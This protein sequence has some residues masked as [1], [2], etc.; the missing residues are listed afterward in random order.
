MFSDFDPSRIVGDQLNGHDRPVKADAFT[1]HDLAAT[2]ELHAAA[3][4]HREGRFCLTQKV[5]L[6]VYDVT[7]VFDHAD[8]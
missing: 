8:E 2:P 1:K 7:K 6:S 3:Q 4:P 5:Q